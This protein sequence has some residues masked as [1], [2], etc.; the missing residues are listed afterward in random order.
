MNT[1]KIIPDWARNLPYA[2]TVCDA[3]GV[4]LYMN[5]RS[6]ATFSP[7]KDIIGTNLM[8]YHPDRAQKMIAHMLETGDT[9]TYT[10]RKRGQKKIIH[11]A[12]WRDDE[13]RIAGLVELSIPIPDTMPHYDR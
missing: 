8:Q 12:P 11:Q 4:I 2:V 7:D 1:D 9:N 10:I 3:Q 13:G 6:K 5:E